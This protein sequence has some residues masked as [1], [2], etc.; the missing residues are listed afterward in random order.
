MSFDIQ[1]DAE[2]HGE[3]RAE[4][5]RLKTALML[6]REVFSKL[7]L[8]AASL[9]SDADEIFKATG[10]ESDVSDLKSVSSKII[11][12]LDQN[13]HAEF[14]KCCPKCNSPTIAKCHVNSPPAHTETDYLVCMDCDHQWNHQ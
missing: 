1:S 2:L 10:D 3:C 13:E 7:R 6:T 8:Y 4:I 14:P 9:N 11:E 12:L 5:N